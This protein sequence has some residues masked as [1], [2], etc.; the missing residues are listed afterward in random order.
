MYFSA[1]SLAVDKG[2]NTWLRQLRQLFDTPHLD[3]PILAALLF[4]DSELLEKLR[5]AGLLAQVKTLIRDR[6]DD[7]VD[8]PLEAAFRYAQARIRP[9]F[10]GKAASTPVQG[11]HRYLDDVR[12][13]YAA[14][15][16]PFDADWVY[17]QLSD[18]SNGP[19]PI[20]PRQVDNALRLLKLLGFLA[21]D[22]ENRAYRRSTAHILDAQA[23]AHDQ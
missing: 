1:E 22:A 5:A 21:Y 16:G 9:L 12:R 19:S 2:R 15:D 8:I 4:E 11:L 14:A 6:I 18:T 20:T 13:A 17:R 10:E 7:S 23:R 3:L